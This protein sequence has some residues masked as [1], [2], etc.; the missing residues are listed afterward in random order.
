MIYF[1]RSKDT[2]KEE[3]ETYAEKLIGY[4]KPQKWKLL[5]LKVTEEE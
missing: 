5:R 2:P 3:D 1:E 4:K